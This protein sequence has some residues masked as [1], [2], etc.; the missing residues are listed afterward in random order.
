MIIFEL[1]I[2][3]Q[4]VCKILILYINILINCTILGFLQAEGQR[5]ESVNAHKTLTNVSVFLFFLF[6]KLKIQHFS[7]ILLLKILLKPRRK[8]RF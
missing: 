2:C 3:V 8:Y 6:E 4:N 5:F 1:V 7:F